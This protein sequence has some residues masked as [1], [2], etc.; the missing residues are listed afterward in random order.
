[1]HTAQPSP[2]NNCYYYGEKSPEDDG[3]ALI[4]HPLDSPGRKPVIPVPYPAIHQEQ[5]LLYALQGVLLPHLHES[6]T[7]TRTESASTAQM[8]QLQLDTL[9]GALRY[10]N[11]KLS[12][13]SCSRSTCAAE[14]LSVQESPAMVK[15]TKVKRSFVTVGK[16]ASAAQIHQLQLDTLNW[17]LRYVSA[18]SSVSSCSW[19]I[20]SAEVVSVGES[21]AML[22]LPKVKR[23][24]VTVGIL[25]SWS[26]GRTTPRSAYTSCYYCSPAGYDTGVMSSRQG[27]R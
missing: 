20:S 21:P 14:V 10:A 23:L 22:Q 11:D 5:S 12:V 9:D 17:A 8:H 16:S 24:F 18:K 19:C 2:K 6:G 7:P 25:G 26:C 4:D 3:P 15:P 27:Y 13:S 1:M